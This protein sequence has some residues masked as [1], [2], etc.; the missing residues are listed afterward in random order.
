MNRE[1]SF[2]LVTINYLNRFNSILDRMIQDMTNARL[3][4]SISVNF[5]TQM[6]PH[7]RAAIEMSQNLLQYTTNIPLQ[8]I[9][10]QIVSEQNKSIENMKSIIGTCGQFS[11]SPQELDAYQRG[12][13][14]IM[15]TMF[16]E[17]EHAC[18][19]NNINVSFIH[20]MIPHHQGAIRMSEL[21]LKASI[22]P[23]LPPILHAI[24][25]SQKRGVMQM[26]QLLQCIC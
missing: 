26:E 10:L 4:N 19:V 24:I 6:I 9:A 25:T 13:D 12:M 1:P 16:S 21:T 3:G 15:D 8:N 14:Q 2:S 5:M 7:H 18:A 22:C 20:E 17:M 11:N 23:Q